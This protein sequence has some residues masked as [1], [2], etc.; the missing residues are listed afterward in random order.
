MRVELGARNFWLFPAA[1]II[2]TLLSA[3]ANGA[4]IRASRNWRCVFENK[5]ASREPKQGVSCDKY[6]SCAP[7]RSSFA[8]QH[9]IES[10]YVDF[11]SR[12][13]TWRSISRLNPSVVGTDEERLA[14][15]IVRE[16]SVA[17]HTALFHSVVELEASGKAAE[18]SEPSTSI[19]LTE[20]GTLSPLLLLTVTKSGYATFLEQGNGS[21]TVWT[22]LYFGTCKAR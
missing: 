12:S 16:E 4:E 17:Q 20:R 1:V 21:D 10:F 19:V 2:S 15:A 8:T 7:T 14:K 11:D 22:T 13:A 9:V 3:S 6:S 18:V 5:E